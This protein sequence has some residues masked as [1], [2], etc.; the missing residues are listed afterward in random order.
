MC[1]NHRE[2]AGFKN[3]FYIYPIE[4]MFKEM[5]SSFNVIPF[6]VPNRL[7]ITWYTIV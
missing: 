7:K 1:Q 3:N 2:K 4:V 6:T 5:L